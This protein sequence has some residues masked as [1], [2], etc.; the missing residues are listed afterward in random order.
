VKYRHPRR[1]LPV[2]Q[3]TSQRSGATIA[4]AVLLA[5]ALAWLFI[6]RAG[7]QSVDPQAPAVVPGEREGAASGPSGQRTSAEH[8]GG[9]AD[10]MISEVDAGSGLRRS[11]PVVQSGRRNGEGASIGQ[12]SGAQVSVRFQ[13]LPSPGEDLGVLVEG[14]SQVYSYSVAEEASGEFEVSMEPGRYRAALFARKPI[15]HGEV[16]DFRVDRQPCTVVLKGCQS[17]SI[18]YFLSDSDDDS[19]IAG[20]RVAINRLNGI[21]GVGL[22]AVK[23][24]EQ[25]RVWVPELAP[26]EYELVES[27]AGYISESQ[28]LILPGDYSPWLVNGTLDLRHRFLL[29]KLKALIQ[30]E[31]ADD[32]G[33]PTGFK[34]SHV[35]GAPGQPVAFDRKGAARLVIG[36]YRIPIEFALTFPNGDQSTYYF[37]ADFR[38]GGEPNII[39]V[40]AEHELHVDLRVSRQH[41]EQLFRHP[42][43]V[44]VAHLGE[45]GSSSQVSRRVYEPG[46]AVFEG[47]FRGAV[48]ASVM[49]FVGGDQVMW[50]ACESSLTK[51]QS[52]SSLIVN[53]S[54]TPLGLRLTEQGEAVGAGANVIVY[55]V[56]DRTGWIAAWD[57]NEDGVVLVPR[58]PRGVLALSCYLNG[59]L[60]AID[61]SIDL[62]ASEDTV[63]LSLDNPVSSKFRVRASGPLPSSAWILVQGAKSVGLEGAALSLSV[64]GDSASLRLTGESQAIA[65]PQLS[66]EYWVERPRVEVAPGLNEIQVVSVGFLLSGELASLSGAESVRLRQKVSRWISEGRTQ[67]TEENGTYMVRVPVGPYVVQRPDGEAIE[68]LV[69]AGEVTVIP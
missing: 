23:S 43:F 48:M 13:F 42:V 67:Y 59:E 40:A 57:T 22:V 30:I 63:E 37:G 31:G 52:R 9:D 18:S 24:D 34:V 15:L 65:T 41:Q 49:Q 29:P 1:R 10:S 64:S 68:V 6:V 27:A 8:S 28:V 19:P 7:Y 32:W 21:R 54:D 25:G 20:G 56:P 2:E 45:D 50:A 35:H 17:F 11:I 62:G 44:Q 3:M 38:F 46:V 39:S 61:H 14:D 5:C 60:R 69:E 47:P 16:V 51:G 53:V 26:G 55:T 66:D 58:I 12:A 33:G 4:C 36:D